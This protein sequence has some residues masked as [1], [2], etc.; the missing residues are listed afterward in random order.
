[1]CLQ[2]PG[3]K[4][5]A[6]HGS[7]WN[8]NSEGLTEGGGPRRGLQNQHV[9][10]ASKWNFRRNEQLGSSERLIQTNIS[11]TTCRRVPKHR[12]YLVKTLSSRVKIGSSSD[13]FNFL[14]IFGSL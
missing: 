5:K 2:N 8:S 13:G 6:S 12:S 1:L 4:R 10:Y 9:K 14:P 11:Q 3:S 7:H